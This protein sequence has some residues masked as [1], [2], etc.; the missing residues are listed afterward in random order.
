MWQGHILLGPFRKMCVCA[1]G[2]VNYF[3][4]CVVNTFKWT[5]S[6]RKDLLWFFDLGHAVDGF[7]I[8]FFSKRSH[9]FLSKLDHQTDSI[10]QLIWGPQ[11]TYSRELPGLCSFRDDAPQE[12]GGSREFRGQVGWG[13]GTFTWRQWGGEEA[14]NVEQLEGGLRGGQ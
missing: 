4:R 1:H 3:C 7:L 9:D 12:T 10:H 8:S 5:T 13:R 6:S 11:H 14:W 2:C